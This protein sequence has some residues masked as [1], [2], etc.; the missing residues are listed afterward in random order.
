[1]KR[2][3]KQKNKIKPF[4]L[5]ST[6]TPPGLLRSRFDAATLR[7]LFIRLFQPEDLT[8]W[9]PVK[10]RGFYQRVFS[11]LVVLWYFIYLRLEDGR[12][13]YDVV[14]DV[15]QGGADPLEAK[16][17]PLSQRLRSWATTSFCKARQRFPLTALA[18]ALSV[19]AQTIRSWTQ[20]LQWHGW[21]VFLLDGSTV[22][23]RPLGDIP[24]H[25]PPH[26]HRRPDRQ[27]WCLIR[28]VV[29]FCLRSAVLTASAVGAITVGE[30]ALAAQLIRAAGPQSLFVGDR[31]FGIFRILQVVRQANVQA[32][33]R[34]MEVRARKLVGG[35][36]LQP[37]L[38]L[39]VQWTHS[40][41]DKLE[42]GAAT[43]PID[44]RLIVARV[45]R[46]GFRPQVLYLF[47]TLLDAK[48]YPAH[49]LLELY[50]WRWH[51]E[52]N[53][54]YLKTQMALDALDCK[55]AEMA[56]KEWLAGLMTYNLIRAA[57][58]AAAMEAKL[59]VLELSF[60][61]AKSQ[62]ARWLIEHLKGSAS[63]AAA[64]KVLCQGIARSRLPKRSKPRPSEPRAKRHFEN[65]FPSLWGS[66]QK[67]R[68]Q[69]KENRVKR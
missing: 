50:G 33:L 54:R 44:G 48:R 59:P 16:G 34:L 27:Y 6:R 17:K 35:R 24:Q 12:R 57:M 37:G 62:V 45:Q 18:Q 21:N 55:S 3:T 14:T 42:P 67:A 63:S 61:A 53:L 69:M 58:L 10:R 31:N 39:L 28:V 38:D 30:Q 56:Q 60:S 66:R 41:H 26:K 52:L 19:Q 20:D 43:D 15:H 36:K 8:G 40:R 22:R 2:A 13:L 46:R 11:P 23:L 47:T 51:V 29:C 4:T 65:S 64:W 9:L 1:M 25:F 32:V 5:P 68:Q 49:Q 7:R